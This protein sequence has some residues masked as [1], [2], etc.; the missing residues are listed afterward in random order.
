MALLQQ[1]PALE[2]SRELPG[3]R[4][5]MVILRGQAAKRG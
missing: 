2:R 4:E 1:F 3:G 5:V